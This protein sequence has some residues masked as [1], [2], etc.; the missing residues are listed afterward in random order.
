M[1]SR[2][3]R[4][5]LLSVVTAR[6]QLVN[7]PSCLM[8]DDATR[9]CWTVGSSEK[10]YGTSIEIASYRIKCHATRHRVA[11]AF[12]ARRCDVKVRP[13]AV[14]SVGLVTKQNDGGDT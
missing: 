6:A 7:H 3:I 14:A 11:T 4:M 12:L 9:P 8:I 2:V 5:R 10:N 13:P 1:R